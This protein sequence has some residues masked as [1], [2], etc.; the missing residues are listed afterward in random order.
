MTPPPGL[1]WCHTLIT[2]EAKANARIAARLL[3]WNIPGVEAAVVNYYLTKYKPEEVAL[4]IRLALG[5][6]LG[7]GEE[8]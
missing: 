5:D 2:R 4:M 6:L 8:D 1:T 7:P 3:G